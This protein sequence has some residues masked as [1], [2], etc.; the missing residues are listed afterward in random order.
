MNSNP[1]SDQT[2]SKTPAPT[3]SQA[4]QTFGTDATVYSSGVKLAPGTTLFFS[5]GDLAANPT[6]D[7]KGQALEAM[8][9]LKGTVTE[10][11]FSLSDVVFVRAYLA[12]DQSGKSD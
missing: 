7:T 10:A 2:S 8:E 9:S 1:S 5:A 11:G 4:F 6:G 12:P 3:P